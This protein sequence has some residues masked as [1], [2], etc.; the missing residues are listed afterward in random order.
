MKT[1]YR[2]ISRKGLFLNDESGLVFGNMLI[3]MAAACSLMLTVLVLAHAIVNF[4]VDYVDTWMLQNETRR[5]FEDMITEI[6]YADKVEY[7]EKSSTKKELIISTRRRAAAMP[8]ETEKYLSFLRE[9]PTMYRNELS[10]LKENLYTVRSTQPLNSGNYFGT[11]KMNFTFKKLQ[12]NLF[13]LEFTGYSYTTDKTVTLHT[14]IL[15]RFI[16]EKNDT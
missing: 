10:K 15:N 11:N 1:V 3:I 5:I 14:V 13:E 12:R 6:E 7:K 2:L 4:F 8:N 16:G 9:G